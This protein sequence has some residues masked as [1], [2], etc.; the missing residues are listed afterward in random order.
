MFRDEAVKLWNRFS[1][2]GFDTNTVLTYSLI[3]ELSGLS[4]ETVRRQAIKLQNNNWVYYSKRNGIKFQPSEDNNKF[5]V[6]NFNAKVIKSFGH[7]LD[8]IE[9]KK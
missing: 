6:D 3:S 9:K 1:K 4:I 2:N 7:L 5:L 8:V